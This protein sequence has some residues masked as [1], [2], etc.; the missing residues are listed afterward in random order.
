MAKTT[1]YFYSIVKGNLQLRGYSFK[2]C[3][4]E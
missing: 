1:K 3:V 2:K 4:R